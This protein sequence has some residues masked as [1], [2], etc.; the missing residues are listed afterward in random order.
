MN[1]GTWPAILEARK[2]RRGNIADTLIFW[3]ETKTADI[4]IL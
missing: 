1:R 2:C 3:R 4:R